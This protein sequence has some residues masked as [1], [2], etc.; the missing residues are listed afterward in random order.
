MPEFNPDP[1]WEEEQ[2]SY[3]IINDLARYICEQA[4]IEDFQK[5]DQGLQ[6][7]DASLKSGD[8]QMRPLVIE[9]LETLFSCPAIAKIKERFSPEVLK[10]WDEY[11]RY[12][13]QGRF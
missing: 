4:T 12:W 7:L 3:P 9:A 2:L 1:L 5:V 6:F 8:E 11:V 13:Q 10:L